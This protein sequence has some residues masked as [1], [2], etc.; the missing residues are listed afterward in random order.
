MNL[1][2]SCIVWKLFLASEVVLHTKCCWFLSNEHKQVR[3]ELRLSSHSPTHTDLPLSFPQGLWAA[4]RS[5]SSHSGGE[6]CGKQN[7]ENI[8]FAFPD[9][10]EELGKRFLL[11]WVLQDRML[12]PSSYL[13]IWMDT[14][15]D[16]IF[17]TERLLW[18]ARW[19]LLSL[20]T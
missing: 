13:H 12:S 5:N 16:F 19:G 1:L 4:S 20:F 15:A 14:F 2:F 11:S 18:N 10:K 7:E 8:D 9:S 17:F 3:T 6:V